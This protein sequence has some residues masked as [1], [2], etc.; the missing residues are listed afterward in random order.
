MTTPRPASTKA[1][2]RAPEEWTDPRHRRGLRGEQIA[3]GFLASL[4]WRLEAH[5]FRVGRHELDLVVRRGR[6]VAFV[7]VK[8][9][10][11]ASYGAGREAIGWR[12]RQTLGRVAEAWRQRFG[13]LGDLYRFDAVEV[14]LSGIGA[15]EVRHWP[16]A[17]RLDRR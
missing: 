6:L 7:E 15:P 13:R 17:W 14:D 5:R 2:G 1:R 12:K 3:I 8:T 9:R 16:D 10:S 11:N 4:G